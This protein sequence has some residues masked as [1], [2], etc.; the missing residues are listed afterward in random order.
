LIILL[1]NNIAITIATSV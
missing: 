1:F